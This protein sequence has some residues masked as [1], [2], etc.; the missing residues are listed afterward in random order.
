MKESAE[1]ALTF[2]RT[3]EEKLGSGRPFRFDV[4]IHV[5]D[6]G[7]PKDG[8]SAGLTIAVALVSAF[9]GKPTRQDVAMTGEITLRGRV[10]PVGGVRE[11]LLAAARGGMRAVILPEAN[12]A[13]LEDLSLDEI[14]DLK[15]YFVTQVEEALAIALKSEAAALAWM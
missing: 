15:L 12:R 14:G 8:P 10:L 3:S 11:K 4:H 1:A 6:A 9:T 2:V 13:D 5:P 7:V